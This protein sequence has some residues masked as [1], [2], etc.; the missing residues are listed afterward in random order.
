MESEDSGCVHYSLLQIC[1]LS[2]VNPPQ[3]LVK[4]FLS[5]HFIIILPLTSKFFT[6]HMRIMYSPSLPSY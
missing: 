2:Q 3:I 5:T 4:D 1:T 6:L